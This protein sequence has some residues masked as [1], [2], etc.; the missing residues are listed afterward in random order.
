MPNQIEPYAPGPGSLAN[1]VVGTPG[2]DRQAG[3]EWFKLADAAGQA[4]EGI[5]R[6][7]MSAAGQ[8][9]G[10][11]DQIAGAVGAAIGRHAFAKQKQS[12][13]LNTN[14]VNTKVYEFQ[15]A[16]NHKQN[17]VQRQFLDSPRGAAGALADVVDNN[18]T[19]PNGKPSFANDKGEPM[20]I[21]S[22]MNWAQNHPSLKNDPQALGHLQDKL[23]SIRQSAIDKS[24]DWGFST[25]TKQA[26]AANGVTTKDAVTS[27][28][29]FSDDMGTNYKSFQSLVANAKQRIADN[30]EFIGPLKSAEDMKVFDKA[31]GTAYI[32]AGIA[33]S[34]EEP[35]AALM[36]LADVRAQLNNADH[37]GISIESGAKAGPNTKVA[38]DADTKIML[39]GKIDTAENHHIEMLKQDMLSSQVGDTASIAARKAY[40]SINAKNIPAQQTAKYWVSDQIK[41]VTQSI[42]AVK[43]NSVLPDKAKNAIITRLTGQLSKLDGIITE[44][45]SNIKS[46]ESDMNADAREARRIANENQRESNAARR[47]AERQAKA[48]HHDRSLEMRDVISQTQDELNQLMLKPVENREAIIQK[49]AE[50]SATVDKAMDARYIAPEKATKVLQ[51]AVGITKTAAEY[52]EKPGFLWYPSTIE[53]IKP[54]SAKGDQL[55]QLQKRQAQYVGQME[56]IRETLA[57]DRRDQYLNEMERGMNSA[58]R[59]EYN[60][61]WPLMRAELQKGGFN[62]AQI[63]QKK[64]LFIARVFQK[65]PAT[66]IKQAPGGPPPPGAKDMQPVAPRQANFPNVKA[67]GRLQPAPA[68]AAISAPTTASSAGYESTPR[69]ALLL[70]RGTLDLTSR[71]VVRFPQG[72]DSTNSTPA[73]RKEFDAKYFPPGSYG[74]EFSATVTV[75]DK[76]VIIPTIFDGKVHSTAEAVAQFKKTKEHMGA[77]PNT[78]EGLKESEKYSTQL[79][80]RTLQVGGKKFTGGEGQ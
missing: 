25:E 17:E 64:E 72:M 41:Q 12:S 78:K 4:R 13:Q 38:L 50:L 8:M 5:A 33:N 35:T 69:P 21:S 74:T 61:K 2:V 37:L 77:F 46:H 14:L 7:Q 76:L 53:H 57:A 66:P 65:I 63:A 28:S 52:K 59:K 79:H 36:H 31:V 6:N 48:D 39:Q 34:P 51:G 56:Q 10:M 68:A 47:D 80:E 27:I 44:A 3:S 54:G 15:G 42:D 24:D 22:V 73:A 55:A 29:Q 70:E 49:A 75:D 1:T 30:A 19:N 71:Q 60:D 16:I 45:D 9:F 18:F 67:S 62:A 11:L 32:E 20:D 58:Q 43:Q 26:E 23:M 40:L